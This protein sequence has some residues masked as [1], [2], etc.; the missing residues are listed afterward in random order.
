M[1]GWSRIKEGFNLST[2]ILD[3]FYPSEINLGVVLYIA[4]SQGRILKTSV[5]L[6]VN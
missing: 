6:L 4:S 5:Y 3:T 1:D 2:A